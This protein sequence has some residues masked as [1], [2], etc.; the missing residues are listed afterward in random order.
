MLWNPYM[1]RNPA[2]TYHFQPSQSTFWSPSD[3]ELY[4]KI[5]KNGVFKG[6][7][8]AFANGKCQYLNFDHAVLF[9]VVCH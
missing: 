1:P 4:P 6:E 9:V 3:P 8:N 2:K 7:Y 5:D